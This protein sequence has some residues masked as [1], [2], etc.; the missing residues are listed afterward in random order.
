MRNEQLPEH[1]DRGVGSTL[2]IHSIFLTIQGE[3]PYAGRQAV[4]IR[5]A[6]CNLQCP[7][8]DT[9]YTSFRVKKDIPRI[10]KDVQLVAERATLIVIT[11]GEPF[12]QRLTPLVTALFRQ[13][14]AIQIESNGT[15][16]EHMFPYGKVLLVVS[17]KTGSINPMLV[18]HIAALK[19]VGSWGD[20]SP[21]DGLPTF[22]LAHPAKPMLARPPE[23]FNGEIFLQPEDSY[24]IQANHRN[25]EAVKDSCRKHGYRLCLQIHKIINVE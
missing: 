4:F 24:N 17:P 18:P 9:D 8:C 2:D 11:G 25:V 1:R 12:R 13:G 3:G 16:Y 5:L 6:G 22:A 20:L 23:G 7:N 21:D 15:L 10:V 14:F 19:Y